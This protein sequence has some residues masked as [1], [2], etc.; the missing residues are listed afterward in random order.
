MAASVLVTADRTLRVDGR[1]DPTDP[2]VR[3]L[4]HA[5]LLC[6]D[7]EAYEL[8][9]S[10]RIEGDPME[11][12]LVVLGRQAGLDPEGLRRDR[13]RLDAIPFDAAHRF[14]ATLHKAVGTEGGFAVIKGA[15]ERIIDMCAQERTPDG[16]GPIDRAAWQRRAAD[17]AAQGHRVLA[18]ATKP[19]AEP[20]GDLAFA[21]V[22]A[23]GVLNG[24][25]GFIDPPRAEA[26]DAVA[27]C[28]AAGTR[29]VMVTGD[30]AET[31]RE[32]ARQL[33]LGETVLTGRDI[34]QL[35]E[36]GLRR[37]AL[38]A[39]VFARTTPG[40]KLRLV[41]ALQAEGLIVAVTGDGVNDAPALK[42]ADVGV[43]MGRKG[44]EAAKEAAEMVLADDNFASIVAAVREGRT[45][46]DNLTKVIGYAL[47]T[48]AGE[49]LMI[50][51]ALAFGLVMPITPLQILWVN[52][53]T[54]VALGLTLAFEPTEPG[55]MRRR[56]RRRDQAML[57]GDLIWRIGFVAALFVAIGF[58]MFFWAD[59][60][61]L[62]IE[63]ART[64]VV[65][66]IVVMEIAYLFSVRYIHGSALTPRG[67]VG[68]PAVLLGVG[69]TIAAQAA[70]TYLPPLQAVFETRALGAGDALAVVA[71]GALLLLVVEIEK[72][73]RLRLR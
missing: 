7:A 66:T 27:E 24:L 62:P 64:L 48:N 32:I 72:W 28:T 41:E 14:M 36:A 33:G 45:V 54:T 43:A 20:T 5:A 70:F 13:P 63:Q 53:V 58:A 2:I 9:G 15:P 39:S 60:R 19:M 67:V 18:F 69:A 38:E 3:D 52:M 59:A 47:P 4:L 71:A 8:D 56:P 50:L 37:A 57:T 35:D 17:L 26:F 68:T 23:D 40:H 46:Y 21:D 30:H 16:V 42:R 61:G 34:D 31:A 11:G 12:A 49:A 44:T 73:L 65:D 25:V 1:V 10:W 22:A 6:N 29:V 51:G 55:T